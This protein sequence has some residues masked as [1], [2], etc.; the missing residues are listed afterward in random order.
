MRAPATICLPLLL[1][2]CLAPG[3]RDPTRYP[4]ERPKPEAQYCIVSLELPGSTGITVGGRSVMHMACN[5]PPRR[6]PPHLYPPR[7]R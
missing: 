7:A 4:W 3:E 6:R 5:P 1:A 2:A